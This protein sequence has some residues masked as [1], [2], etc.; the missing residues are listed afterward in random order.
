MTKG[1]LMINT[2]DG[3]GKTT[4]ALGLALRALGHGFK[5]CI[6][7]FIKN[8]KNTG[9]LKALQVFGNQISVHVMGR[10][11]TWESENFEEDKAIG[12][13]AWEYAKEII[14]SKQYDLVILDELTY[15]IT[16]KMVREE[17]II[18]FLIKRP[19]NLHVVIT[20]RGASE[21]LMVAA[22]LVTQLQALKHPFNLG[23]KAQ[24][25]VEF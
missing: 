7:Q 14:K 21:N 2:G 22:D 13:Q 11:F 12:R 10:G 24:K 25:G 4:A 19:I 3:K 17:E 5:V 18:D 16:F 23:V 8:N 6:I 20:G 15:L 1:L 9:E